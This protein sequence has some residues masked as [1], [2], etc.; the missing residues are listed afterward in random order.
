MTLRNTS[1]GEKLAAWVTDHYPKLIVFGV[2][3]GIW[4]FGAPLINTGETELLPTFT[5]IVMGLATEHRE[6]ILS[7]TRNTIIH[8]LVGFVIAII[9]GLLA[10]VIM[11]EIELIRQATFPMIVFSESIPHAL[12]APLFLLWFGSETV[13]I[14]LFAAW[15]ASF[16]VLLNTLTGM[17][18]TDEEF[19]HLGELF[20]ATRWQMLKEIKFW[21][22]L[23][24]IS[25]GI[26]I[27]VSQSVIGVILA[28]FFGSGVG[29]AFQIRQGQKFIQPD[30]MWGSIFLLIGITFVIFMA[31]ER[32]IDSIIPTESSGENIIG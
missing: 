19:R 26:K 15:G 27:A 9:V 32:I 25:T 11:S 21:N 10:G 5:A 1:P 2:L 16:P 12:L 29:L 24:H 4:Q 14:A 22:A 6:L 8:I 3:I 7:A 18:Q 23:P 28:E 20:G 31:S 17:Q 13:G 30:L